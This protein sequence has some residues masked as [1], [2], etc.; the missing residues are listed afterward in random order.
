MVELFNHKVYKVFPQYEPVATIGST[1]IVYI[2][3]LPGP[4][5][6]LPKKKK[7]SYSRYHHDDEEEQPPVDENQL[8]VFPVYCAIKGKSE[9]T[10]THSE[11]VTQFGD[12]IVLA[13]THKEASQPELLYKLVSQHVERYT[14]F[15]LFEEVSEEVVNDISDMVDSQEDDPPEY[16]MIMSEQEDTNPT[17]EQGYTFIEKAESPVEEEEEGVMVDDIKPIHTA[18]AVTAAGGKKTQ[19]M[20]NL[21]TMKVFASRGYSRGSEELLPSVQS[22]SGLVDLQERAESEEK[23]RQAYYQQQQEVEEES[24]VDTEMEESIVLPSKMDDEDEVEDAATLFATPSASIEEEETITALPIVEP[25]VLPKCKL[26]LPPSTIIRQGEGILLEWTVKKAQQLFGH[27]KNI[28]GVCADA[29]EDIEELGDPNVDTS[30]QQQ[31]KQ[32]TLSDCMDE[33]TKEEELSEED[34]WYCPKCKK[35]QRATKKFDL[36]RMP[37]IMVVHLKRFSHSRTWRDKIDALIDFPASEL[38]LTD[39]VLSIEDHDDLPQEDRLIYDL[40]GVDNHYG[41]LG[42]GHCKYILLLKEKVRLTFF[43][44]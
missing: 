32:I 6:P 22:W 34:L 31:K 33:F 7:Y 8:V 9:S 38:D 17:E 26:T 41:G 4:V 37:E 20:S 40:Y 29:W 39:R 25:P 5:P 18:A 30:E 28:S 2:Y 14:Q 23:Q 36:W 1:D 15:K 13:M 27:N 10:Y 19:P 42:G 11:S 21:F 12:P 24:S 3:Q 44:L 35:H 16:E 43:T